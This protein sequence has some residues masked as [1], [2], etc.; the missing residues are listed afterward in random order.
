MT[1]D[2][3]IRDLE[4]LTESLAA[5]NRH[6][7]TPQVIIHERQNT[8]EANPN[9]LTATINRLGQRVDGIASE[10]KT[11][12]ELQKGLSQSHKEQG[13]RVDKLVIAIGE[14]IQR[15]PAK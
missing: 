13:E 1:N 10:V 11:L 15:L 9:A 14:L 6:L 2:E 3:R 8:F 4:R 12:A 5:A 7:L